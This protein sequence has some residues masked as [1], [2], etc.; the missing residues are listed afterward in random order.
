MDLCPPDAIFGGGK[1]PSLDVRLEKQNSHSPPGSADGDGT[2]AAKLCKAGWTEEEDAIVHVSVRA[3]GTQWQA[4][5]DRLPGRTADAVRNR[6]H[7]LQ[8]RGSHGGNPTGEALDQLV[9]TSAWCTEAGTH[10]DDGPVV[11]GSSRAHAQADA[12]SGVV[13]VTGSDHGRAKW[14]AEEDGTILQGVKTLG[15]RWRE[16]AALLPGRSDSS[17]RNRWHRMLVRGQVSEETAAAAAS[18]T[19][20]KG[21]GRSSGTAAS[22][23]TF[24]SAQAPGVLGGSSSPRP[25]EGGWPN[26]SRFVSS[27]SVLS[28]PPLISE[29]SFEALATQL[30]A[31]PCSATATG[32]PS[33]VDRADGGGLMAL[34]LVAFASQSLEPSANGR[35]DSRAAKETVMDGKVVAAAGYEDQAD[36]EADGSQIGE[37][38]H[39]AAPTATLV[40]S[41]AGGE[42]GFSS[43]PLLVD[44]LG[45]SHRLAGSTVAPAGYQTT[46][47]A[48]V[49][50]DDET[51]SAIASCS[52]SLTDSACGA[53]EEGVA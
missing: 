10:R 23:A 26:L 45:D 21:V 19:P 42:P 5:A 33:A 4:V 1:P 22:S 8:K 27:S 38:A 20:S 47:L 11:P 7:R 12:S 40:A 44:G 29:Q 28:V 13:M 35:P 34:A 18:A 48:M 17:I 52:A 43:A 41:A 25:P 6:W 37:Q 15:C 14:S 30:P 9:L 53:S 24:R 51:C 39:T 32:A 50:D 2:G 46:P 31:A 36:E 16:I 3:L 49:V